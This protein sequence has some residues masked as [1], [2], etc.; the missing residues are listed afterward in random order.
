M[1]ILNETGF[2]VDSS[3]LNWLVLQTSQTSGITL[4]PHFTIY[5]CYHNG[6]IYG[7]SI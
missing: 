3:R 7:L 6:I 2:A 1:R 4:I 5:Q